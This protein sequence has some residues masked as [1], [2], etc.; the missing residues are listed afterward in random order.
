ME[1]RAVGVK[2]NSMFT[3]WVDGPDVYA[4]DQSRPRVFGTFLA[5]FYMNEPA[6]DS[7]FGK[8]QKRGT[9]AG[10]LNLNSGKR[11]QAT[12]PWFTNMASKHVDVSN[13]GL[14]HIH[15]EQV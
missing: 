15:R 12:H 9:L 2:T 10:H 3:N 13:L 6:Y 5:T 1:S 11:A 7:L 14:R 4:I 8:D